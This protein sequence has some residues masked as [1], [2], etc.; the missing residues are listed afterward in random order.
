MFKFLFA[1]IDDFNCEYNS[2][3]EVQFLLQLMKN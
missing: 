2:V 1:M 3:L